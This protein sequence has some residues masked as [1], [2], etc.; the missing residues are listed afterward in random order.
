MGAEVD[1]GAP[2]ATGRPAFAQ[3]GM[4]RPLE[5]APSGSPF[6]STSRL[7]SIRPANVPLQTL[8]AR[9]D[10]RPG[11]RP[12]CRSRRRAPHAG[13]G[14]KQGVGVIIGALVMLAGLY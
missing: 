13:F 7:R 6:A 10:S 12:L 3:R 9:R 1:Y 5:A 2:G 14:W 11:G 8:G 4:S